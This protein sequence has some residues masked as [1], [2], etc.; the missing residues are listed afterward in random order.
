MRRHQRCEDK[1]VLDPLA[2]AQRAQVGTRRSAGA[3]E[4]AGVAAQLAE[5]SGQ[6][7]RRAHADGMTGAFPACEVAPVAANVV[8]SALS[9]RIEQHFGSGWP[10]L[11][12]TAVGG[13]VAGSPNRFGQRR[14]YPRIGI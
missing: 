1:C 5:I 3:G 13:E 7:G 2:R 10:T 4:K 6:P 11:T 9:E 8:K 14:H 12:D